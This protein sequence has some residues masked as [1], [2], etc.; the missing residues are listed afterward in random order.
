LQHGENSAAAQ[1]N[2][3]NPPAQRP[4]V[5]EADLQPVDEN[6]RVGVDELQIAPQVRSSFIY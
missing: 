2:E 6:I 5:A 3:V 4:V 1:R